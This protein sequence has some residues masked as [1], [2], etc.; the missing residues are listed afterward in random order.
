MVR[1]K[2]NTV[3]T[4]RVVGPG[5]EGR[6]RRVEWLARLKKNTV[7]TGRVLDPPENEFQVIEEKPVISSNVKN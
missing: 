4:D 5:E 1:L 2:K 6:N 7:Q 3:Q